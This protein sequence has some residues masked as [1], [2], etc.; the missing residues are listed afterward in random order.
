[1][2]KTKSKTPSKTI[3]RPVVRE[4]PVRTR[5]FNA[6]EEEWERFNAMLPKGNARKAFLLLL[7]LLEEKIGMPEDREGE[8]GPE[9]LVTFY[10]ANTDEKDAP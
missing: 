6:S 2:A 8:S 4:H 9:Y 10:E 1:M 5:R 7:T 3:G